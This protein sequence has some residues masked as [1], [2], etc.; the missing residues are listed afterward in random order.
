MNRQ[1]DPTYR[2]DAGN[3]SVNDA[4]KAETGIQCPRYSDK[5]GGYRHA[6][7]DALNDKIK[8]LSHQIHYVHTPTLQPLFGAVKSRESF[9]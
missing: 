4:E 3:G 6:H 5:A 1:E 2:Q 9:P 7:K 8:Q